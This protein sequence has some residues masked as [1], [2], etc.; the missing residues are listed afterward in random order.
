MLLHIL[1]ETYAICQLDASAG[2]PMEVLACPFFALVQHPEGTSLIVPE[3]MVAAHWQAVRG[4]R[5]FQIQDAMHQQYGG[6]LELTSSLASLQLNTLTVSSFSHD[7][8]FVP[9]GEFGMARQTFA[10]QGH[11]I[12]NLTDWS[13]PNGG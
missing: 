13:A 5:G 7:Y 12:V 3:K 10:Q 11:V 8:L 4:W 9:V 6:L 1:P 2:L